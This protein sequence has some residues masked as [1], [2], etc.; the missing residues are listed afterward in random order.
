MTI[1]L[2]VIILA[3]RTAINLYM[4][5]DKTLNRAYNY[6]IE[7]DTLFTPIYTVVFTTIVELL[8]VATLLKSLYFSF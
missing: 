2:L 3:V 4:V 6:S 7:H 1:S 8:P 5:V